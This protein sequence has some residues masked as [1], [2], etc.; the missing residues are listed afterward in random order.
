MEMMRTSQLHVVNQPVRVESKDVDVHTVIVENGYVFTTWE[1]LCQAI[2]K[3]LDDKCLEW[4]KQIKDGSVHWYVLDDVTGDDHYIP[5]TAQ[6]LLSC[7]RYGFINLNSYDSVAQALAKPPIDDPTLPAANID[8]DIRIT[9]TTVEDEG[10]DSV[11]RVRR[12]FDP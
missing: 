12:V 4:I 9:D 3:R 6:S 8:Q 7:P 10:Q 11:V 5:E 1:H 2:L